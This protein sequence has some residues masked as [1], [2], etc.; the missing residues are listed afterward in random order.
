VLAI[1]SVW[2]VFCRLS[3]SAEPA[4]YSLWGLLQTKEL[5]CRPPKTT[6]CLARCSKYTSASSKRGTAFQWCA[7][8]KIWD[9]RPS[10]A[11]TWTSSRPAE[12]LE[13]G[14]VKGDDEGSHI[15][16]RGADGAVYP[17]LQSSESSQP[18][19][20]RCVRLSDILV[21]TAVE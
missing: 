6:S 10:I 11:P 9:K 2:P 8:G 16:N 3:I 1:G 5:P 20:D 17:P 19:A 13:I 14:R 21:A 7:N 12:I 15:C 18:G 4:S